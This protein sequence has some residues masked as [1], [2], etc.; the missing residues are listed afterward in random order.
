MAL[1][2]VIVESQR[3]QVTAATGPVSFEFL[4][5]NADP[6]QPAI[7]LL[8]RR[9]VY[10]TMPME[11]NEV[12]IANGVRENNLGDFHGQTSLV[13]ARLLRDGD[14][15]NVL[16]MRTGYLFSPNEVDNIVLLY[17]TK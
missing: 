7:L 2:F 12:V 17:R 10:E 4:T 14:E 8:D 11:L 1:E 9:H 15:K 5:R 16:V 6:D 3:T 13:R